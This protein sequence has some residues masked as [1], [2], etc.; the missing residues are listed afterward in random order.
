ML[1]PRTHIHCR[2]RTRREAGPVQGSG[3]APQAC[4]KTPRP[5]HGRRRKRPQ[6]VLLHDRTDLGAGHFFVL[7][8][9]HVAGT[10]DF[11]HS[12]FSSDPSCFL[13]VVALTFF[14]VVIGPGACGGGGGRNGR[15]RR[16]GR[17]GGGGRGGA[18]GAA[19]EAGGGAVVPAVIVQGRTIFANA[20]EYTPYRKPLCC[21]SPPPPSLSRPCLPHLTLAFYPPR[22]RP[23][24]PAP[25][26][27]ETHKDDTNKATGGCLTVRLLRLDLQV[28]SP[29]LALQHP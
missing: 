4:P 11:S 26:Q 27:L 5:P 25:V 7:V 8:A 29:I 21:P 6:G 28:P 3:N 13:S 18:R 22:L 17:G 23:C 14:M 15:R 12:Y 10:S 24:V 16:R 1:C 19:E 9:E 2:W 20:P